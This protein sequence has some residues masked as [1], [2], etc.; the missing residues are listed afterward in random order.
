[1]KQGIRMWTRRLMITGAMV[2][3]GAAGCSTSAD[4]AP[5]A[6]PSPV[7]AVSIPADPAQAFAAAKARLGTESAH[8]AQDTGGDLYGYTGTVDAKTGNWE[9]TGKYYVVRRVGTELY[10]Q[11]TGKLP[12]STFIDP[13]ILE[14][15]NAGGWAHTPL[16]N[17]REYSVVFNDKFPWNLAN[18]ALQAK[19]VTK[20]GDRTFTGTR[21]ITQSPY[22][23]HPTRKDLKVSATLDDQGR[24]AEIDL[25]ADPKNPTRPTIFRF[26]DYGTPA[27]ITAPPPGDVV[28]AD[29]TILSALVLL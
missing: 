14:R 20:T 9:I 27:A 3:A 21:T 19:R 28:E 22:T 11:V 12:D 5:V 13:A 26:T 1:M 4:H 17:G 6:S 7:P 24:F 23:S 18:P 10:V 2:L 29:P 25:Y 15:L 16:L 8:F